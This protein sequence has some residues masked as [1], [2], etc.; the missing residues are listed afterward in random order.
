MGLFATASLT[1]AAPTEQHTVWCSLHL[2]K[3]SLHFTQAHHITW[4]ALLC[5]AVN[6]PPPNYLLSSCYIHNLMVDTL[7]CVDIETYF[8]S[9]LISILLQSK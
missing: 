4:A 2:Y 7:G 1:L 5:S 9:I 3:M 8:Y 6:A